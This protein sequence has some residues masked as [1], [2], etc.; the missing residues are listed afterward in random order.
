MA[1]GATTP[2]RVLAVDD[3]P[4]LLATVEAA[5]API[6][7]VVTATTGEEA[8]GYAR[9]EEFACVLL[10]VGLPGVDGF[11]TARRLAA[12]AGPRRVPV[13]FVS[14]HIDE[15]AVRRG[16]DVGAAD[17]LLKPFEPE[18]LRAKV[19]VFVDLEELRRET[20]VL[21]HRSLHDGLTGLPNR[22]LFLDRTELALARIVREPALVAVLF[23]DLDGFKEANDRLGHDAGDRLLVEVAARLQD[24]I[25]ATDTAARFGGDEFLV[26]CEDLH[27][28][29]EVEQVEQRLHAVLGRSYDL[30]GRSVT[31]SAAIG[32]AC[33][34]DPSARPEALIRAADEAMLRAKA[35]ARRRRPSRAERR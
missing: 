16:Y 11:E 14:G 10:D 7:D 4:G 19:A 26:L 34:D 32:H 20:E 8:L 31:L 15:A 30:D 35:R 5:L 25:R 3:D 13:I 23:L 24:S 33:T 17:Y 27:E 2:V 9:Q 29:H 22:T 21:S 18:I 12:Q 6:A 28:E 1:E